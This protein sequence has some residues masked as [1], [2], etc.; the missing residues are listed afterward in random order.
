M[1]VPPTVLRRKIGF[2]QSHGILVET[3]LDVFSILENSKSKD[4]GIQEGLFVDDYEAESA[5][6][7]AQDQREEELQVYFYENKQNSMLFIFMYFF[8]SDFLV[9]YCWYADEFGYFTSGEDT[10][11]VENVCFSRTNT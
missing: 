10:S 9:I 1:Q 7:S 11:D 6:A 8:V 4:T 3:S 5:M 2:W